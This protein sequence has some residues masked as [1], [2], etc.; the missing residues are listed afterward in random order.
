MV[1]ISNV[2]V[3]YRG[4]ERLGRINLEIQRGEFVFLVGPS[5]AGKS[6]VLKLIYMEHRP[7]EGQV[8]VA[9]YDSQSIRR[10]EIP[11]LRRKLGIIFQD[12]KLLSDR[13]VFENVAFVL[14]VT[15]AK[16]REIKRR[17]LRI[18]NDVGLI[19]KR[20]KMPNQLSG[21][22][23]QRVAIARALVNEPFILL[24]DEPTGNLDHE[25][26]ENIMQLLER[27]NARGTA[28]LMATHDFNLVQHRGRRIIQIER[29]HTIN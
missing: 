2:M 22:E 17:V 21:G 8:V 19:H 1:R 5:G 6:T 14:R 13:N 25:N 27:I 24:A 16:T 3:Q 23:Q 12:F 10:M 20:N 26:A 18:L 11:F 29:G 15:H 9:R 28:I 7:L 4:G